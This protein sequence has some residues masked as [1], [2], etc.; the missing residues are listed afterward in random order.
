MADTLIPFDIATLLDSDE[1]ISEYLSQILADGDTDE[2][3]RALGHVAR[4]R[5]MA[6][7]SRDSGLGRASL[8]KTFAPG[9][10][11]RFDTVLKVMRALGI[12]LRTHVPHA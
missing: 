3:L 7:V 5:G 12:E 1:A 10:K 8:Y 4:A 2:L 6:Q 9:A 11:P